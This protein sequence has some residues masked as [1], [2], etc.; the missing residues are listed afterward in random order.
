[1]ASQVAKQ[2]LKSGGHKI[3]SCYTRNYEKGRAFAE[4]FGATAYER[5]EDAVCAQGVDGVYVVTPHNAHY[6]FV[7]LALELGKP[8]LCE[9]TFTVNA[10][11]TRELIRLASKK[12]L[13]L[14]EAMW[15]WF[16]PAAHQVRTW[17]KD[18]Q[19]GKV[20]SADFTYHMRS[21][22]YA[23]RVSD[24]K[25]AGGALLDITIYP[26]TYAYR[27]FG[28]PE[29][30]QSSGV[31]QNGIDVSE[32]VTL[33]FPGGVTSHISASILDMKGF[34]RM[35]ITGDSGKI[36]ATMYHAMNRA[37]LRKSFWKRTKFRGPGSVINSYVTEFDAVAAD[38]RAG[39]TES[40]LVPLQCT[41]DV[42]NILDT[43]RHQIGLTYPNLE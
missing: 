38:I 36:K 31:I 34:E 30:I 1:M 33:T 23:P 27:L 25:R 28:Y 17:V 12:N 22:D 6:R 24:P 3:V 21:I 43:I 14:A 13:Y 10:E 9:K 20:R 7:K 8:V 40:D 26:I 15:T 2:I 18:G 11:E 42:M 29:T 37:T 32:E 41:Q 5:P 35:T 39:K 19:I 16:S 4:K